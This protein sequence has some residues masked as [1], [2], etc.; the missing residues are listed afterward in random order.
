MTDLMTNKEFWALVYLEYVR[1]GSQ[2]GDAAANAS[3]AV[4]KRE[5]ALA[6]HKVY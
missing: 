2:H 4:V 1:R 5:Q 3:D 6:G